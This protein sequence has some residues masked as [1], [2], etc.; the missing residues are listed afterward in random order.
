MSGVDK[1]EKAGPRLF[2]KQV[3]EKGSPPSKNTSER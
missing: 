3:Y 1:D 2:W